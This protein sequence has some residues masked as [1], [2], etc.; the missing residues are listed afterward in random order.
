MQLRHAPGLV[1]GLRHPFPTDRN[2]EQLRPDNYFRAPSMNIVIC[3]NTTNS[4]R[5][6]PSTLGEHTT[7]SIADAI[8]QPNIPNGLWCIHRT[9]WENGYCFN[10]LKKDGTEALINQSRE[11]NSVVLW[12][13]GGDLD[14]FSPG[15]GEKYPFIVPHGIGVENTFFKN[16][17]IL[18]NSASGK[19]GKELTE[20]FMKWIK[21]IRPSSVPEAL[22]AAYLLLSAHEKMDKPWNELTF[23]H[24]IAAG[25]QYQ[26]IGGDENTDW[27]HVSEWDEDKIRDIKIK[28]GKLFSRVVPN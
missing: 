13:S 19:T 7:L 2:I 4:F 15:F 3:D 26:E 25:Q 16:I 11:N 1:V 8:L 5:T 10:Y 14:N 6:W 22:V 28:I 21:Q 17:G 27:C 9:D 12:Y 23:T 20:S 24:W 18:L